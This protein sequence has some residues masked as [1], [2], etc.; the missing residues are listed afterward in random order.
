MNTLSLF[1]SAERAG[2]RHVALDREFCRFGI[3]R[4]AVVEFDVRPEFYRHLLAVGGG[5]VRQ[6]ELRHDVELL[7]D[8]EQLVAERREHDTTDIGAS[9]RRIEDVG[10]LGEADPQRRFGTSASPERQQHRRRQHCQT[11]ALHPD[12]PMFTVEPQMSRPH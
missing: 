3:E 2:Q 9:E 7:V 10:V 12:N 8:V 5:L 1:Q 11:Q 6:R 4:L